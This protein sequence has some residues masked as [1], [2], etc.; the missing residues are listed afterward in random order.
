VHLE[1]YVWM[2]ILVGL[3]LPPLAHTDEPWLPAFDLCCAFSAFCT[4]TQTED[5]KIFQSWKNRWIYLINSLLIW[6]IITSS[7]FT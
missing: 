7:H 5:L 2:N 4:H 1:V 6:Q 3:R